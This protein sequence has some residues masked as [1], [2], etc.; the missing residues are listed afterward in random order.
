[1]LYCVCRKKWK[2]HESG[3]ILT[4]AALHFGTPIKPVPAEPRHRRIWCRKKGYSEVYCTLRGWWLS[5]SILRR[6]KIEESNLRGGCG[7]SVLP[8][9]VFL[10]AFAPLGQQLRTWVVYQ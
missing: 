7:Y 2:N 3:F 5:M 9:V 10:Y 1:M 8:D 6:S 4:D